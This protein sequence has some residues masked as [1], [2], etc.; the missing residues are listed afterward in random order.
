MAAIRPV[1]L[2][3]LRD[4]PRM[5]RWFAPVLMAKLVWNVVV[6]QLFGQF[7]DRR[8]IVAALDPLPDEKIVER[9]RQFL[10]DVGNP[11]FSAFSP[12]A[13][14]ALWID[15]V[16][17]LGDGFD[18][19]YAIASL[20][21]QEE[22]TVDGRRTQRGK[23]LVM[24][25]DEVYP[26]ASDE[27][28]NLKLRAPY[29]WAFPDLDPASDKGPPVY[30]VPG[31]H[32]WYDGLVRFMGLFARREP[33]RLG[34]WRAHQHR[35]YF[36]LQLTERWWIWGIDAQLDE[37]VDQPQKDY[38]TAIAKAMKPGSRLIL[39]GPEPGWLYAWRKTD[40]PSLAV[41]DSIVAL[42]DERC[43]HLAIPL[44]LSGDTHHYSRYLADDGKT[45]FV[46][47]GGGGAFLHPTHQLRA[48]I[49]LANA[50]GPLWRKGALKILKLGR[51]ND[52]AAREACYPSRKESR[53]MLKG[54][55]A[56]PFFNPGFA[57]TC[58]V[59]YAAGM[60]LAARFGADSFAWITTLFCACFYLY[61]RR[62]QGGGAKIIMLALVN[63]AA[64]G[65]ALIALDHGLGRISS[66]LAL[67]DGWPRLR[68]LAEAV[69]AIGASG[70]VGAT[71][72]GLSLYIAARLFDLSHNDAFSA[73]RRNS[74]RHFLR[75]RIKDDC[76]EVF[77][78]ALDKT[79]R[80]RDWRLNIAARGKPAPVYVPEQPLAPRLIE[81]P[82]LAR[83]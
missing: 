83:P 5:T 78:I 51:S 49:A 44:I 12:D 37:A 60:A 34:G 75:I 20:L 45:Q 3:R 63:G 33:L 19:T 15:Y 77:A 67:A 35:S 1:S 36:A 7:A 13:E 81:P 48:E 65:A 57:L 28:Y 80:R 70:A 50:D 27:N 32:D 21:A 68:F 26:N 31:N 61:F 30:A 73:M 11:R 6:A 54:V 14:G 43:A 56:F 42:A 39:C 71:I 55:L 16:A 76:A 53:A 74:H 40:L 47:S 23:L 66:W 59:V 22:L 69:M 52:E 9:A 2:Q 46:T 29:D 25:G 4:F 17:D 41:I 24:G 10:P 62:Q 18:S 8:L 64:H 38:F 82:F 72:F 79:P 58:G